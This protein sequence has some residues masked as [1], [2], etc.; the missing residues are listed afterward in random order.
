MGG[1][2]LGLGVRHGVCMCRAYQA[3]LQLRI[4]FLCDAWTRNSQYF[5]LLPRDMFTVP[6]DMFL[7][8]VIHISELLDSPGTSQ[9]FAHPASTP[10]LL[11]I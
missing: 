4:T 3:I 8:I 9:F 11:F 1:C 6:L 7:Y 2:R 10:V 5:P